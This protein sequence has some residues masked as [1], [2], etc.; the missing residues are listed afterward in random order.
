VPVRVESA[1]AEMATGPAVP[2]RAHAGACGASFRAVPC[3]GIGWITSFFSSSG[4]VHQVMRT[5]DLIT[6]LNTGQSG[7]IVSGAGVM[8][9]VTDRHGRLHQIM[10]DGSMSTDLTTGTTY[11]EI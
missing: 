8:A 4:G 6:D 11:F 1:P 7:F 10:K 5:G 9:M 2:R 3:P